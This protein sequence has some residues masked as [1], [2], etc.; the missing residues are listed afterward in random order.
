MNV[1]Y[2]TNK[3]M[4]FVLLCVPILYAINGLSKL[5]ECKTATVRLPTVT[6]VTSIPDMTCTN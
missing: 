4:K 5:S 3:A 6:T 1:G 2:V